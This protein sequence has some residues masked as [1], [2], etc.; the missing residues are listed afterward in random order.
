MDSYNDKPVDITGMLSFSEDH[1]YA[2]AE[3]TITSM[4][5]DGFV[6]TARHGMFYRGSLNEEQPV[7]LFIFTRQITGV[8]ETY[9]NAEQT[10]DAYNT[11]WHYEKVYVV[12]DDKG[13]LRVEYSNPYELL[14]TVMEET[15]LLP[16]DQIRSIFEKMVVI[17]NNAVDDNP[18]WSDSGKME[19]HIATVQLGLINVREQNKDTGLLVPAWDFMGYTRGRMSADHQWGGANSNELISFLTINAI[20]GSIIERGY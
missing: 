16:F 10:S 13:V 4:N 9:T 18:V 11:S 8:K 20:D 15:E 7:Y 14:G 19:Y 12:I 2:L 6:C 5:L 1:A 17:V 3:K